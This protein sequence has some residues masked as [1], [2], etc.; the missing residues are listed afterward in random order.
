[1]TT[2]DCEKSNG[3][4]DSSTDKLTADT[5]SE[6]EDSLF[7]NLNGVKSSGLSVDDR[8]VTV[9]GSTNLNVNEEDLNSVDKNDTEVTAKVTVSLSNGVGHNVNDE[10]EE[11]DIDEAGVEENT[12]VSETETANDELTMDV[13]DAVAEE[14]QSEMEVEIT[15]KF[16]HEVDTE[17]DMQEESEDV[18]TSELTVTKTVNENRIVEVTELKETEKSLLNEKQPLLTTTTALLKSQQKLLVES[19]AISV[20]E[21]NEKESTREEQLNNKVAVSET[22]ISE[23]LHVEMKPEKMPVVEPGDAKTTENNV[24]QVR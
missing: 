21:I 2:E 1:M 10:V 22:N 16:E 24:T 11:E 13:D 14:S 15:S 6:A 19:N 18:P 12:L 3:E 4:S 23:N 9:T 5:R 8:S 17:A 20:S 7:S